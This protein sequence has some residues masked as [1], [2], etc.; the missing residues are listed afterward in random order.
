MKFFIWL[1]F[2]MSLPRWSLCFLVSTDYR[3][4]VRRTMRTFQHPR[5]SVISNDG[6]KYIGCGERLQDVGV[7]RHVSVCCTH[8]LWNSCGWYYSFSTDCFCSEAILPF[9]ITRLVAF[10]NGLVPFLSHEYLWSSQNIKD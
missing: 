2:G 8:S 5:L 10:L 7:L 1:K 6:F 9:C 4:D 3:S